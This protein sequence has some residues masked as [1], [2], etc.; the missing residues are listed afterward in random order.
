MLCRAD[1]IGVFQ[2]ESGLRW[3]RCRAC[4]PRRFYDLVVEVALIRPGPIQGGSVHPFVRRKHGLEGGHLPASEAGEAAQQ[5][6]R[7][8]DLSGAADA[9]GDRC[10]GGGR[11]TRPT[12]SVG[13]WAPSAGRAHESVRGTASTQGMA[14]NGLPVSTRMRSSSKLAAFA[15]FGFAGSRSLWFG[16]LVYA[17]FMDQAL[18]SGGVLARSCQRSADGLLLHPDAR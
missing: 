11:G 1:S 2:V 7:H 16:Y 10:A 17:S 18:L 14:T 12:S 5:D 15:N 3:P 6:A 9:D 8:P 4:K 13:R